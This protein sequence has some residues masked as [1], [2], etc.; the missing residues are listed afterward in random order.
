MRELTA[1]Q[2]KN[3]VVATRVARNLHDIF[4]NMCLRERNN[5]LCG[6]PDTT[7][8]FWEEYYEPAIKAALEEGE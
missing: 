7:E 8:G 3:R 2:E 4:H 6:E 1:E 5:A